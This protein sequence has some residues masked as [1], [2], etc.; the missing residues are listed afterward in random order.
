M[1]GRTREQG[2]DLTGDEGAGAGEVVSCT[3]VERVAHL[4][5]ERPAKRNALDLAVFDA[6]VA[7][8]TRLAADGAIGAVVL[9]GRG[10]HFSAGLDVSLF[11]S[12][13]G[14]DIGPA[15]IARLQGVLDAIEDLPVPT[16]AALDGVCLG[17]GL[18]LALACD[19]RAV[20]PD[21]RLSVMESR[22]GL[23]PDLGGTWRLP[24]L[25]GQGRAIELALTARD[26]DADE[27]QRIGLAEVALP[28]GDAAA[29]VHGLAAR[30]AVG[31][32]ALRHVPRLM[33]ENWGRERAHAQAAEAAAQLE[34]LR[35]P[36]LAE[37]VTAHLEGRPPRF[38]AEGAASQVLPPEDPG[39]QAVSGGPDSA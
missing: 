9:S 21:V 16:I 27:A 37:A 1:A 28:R 15:T 26:V 38:V 33:R 13:V 5:I 19:L 39:P 14:A 32:A 18:Q 12:L 31:P 6:L 17:G 8:A 25:V 30:L 3:V 35:G 29:G 10:E 23:I 4:V 34:L 2:P 7:H 36:D 22:W 11:P 20:T 24:R